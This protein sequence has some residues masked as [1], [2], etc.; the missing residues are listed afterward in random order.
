MA[1]NRMTTWFCQFPLLSP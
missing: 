1:V